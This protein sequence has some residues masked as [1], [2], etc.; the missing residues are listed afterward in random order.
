[1]VPED[2][3]LSITPTKG[4]ILVKRIPDGEDGDSGLIIPDSVRAEP[5][6]KSRKCILVSASERAREEILELL[7]ISWEEISSPPKIT[8]F[9]SR[10]AG[11]EFSYS[12]DKQYVLIRMED[13]LAVQEESDG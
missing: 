12:Q 5:R 1:M 11:M 6:N 9:I 3:L 7:E 13:V 2:K 8:V 10:N 4:R